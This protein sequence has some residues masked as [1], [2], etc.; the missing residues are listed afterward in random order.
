MKTTTFAPRP[1]VAAADVRR[2]AARVA[3]RVRPVTLIPA[4]A[5]SPGR[6]G[7][8]LASE[9]GQYSGSF[10]ARGAANLV[11]YHLE[12]GS[13]PAAGVVTA[14][15][16]SGNAGLACAWAA[17][18]TDTRATV[19]VP[20]HCPA[21]LVRRLREAGAEVR[22][23]GDAFAAAEAAA[24]AY[25][26]ETGAVLA[27]GHGDPLIAAGAGTLAAELDAAIGGEVDTVVVPVGSG[28]LLAGTCAA[29][30]ATGIKVVG[31]R[32]G[33]PG[34]GPR[35][36]EYAP[37]ACCPVRGAAS[38]VSVAVSH[39]DALHA[40]RAAWRRWR[41]AIEPAA[42]PALAAVLYGAYRPEVFERLAVVLTGANTDPADLPLY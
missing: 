8:Y 16:R 20:A 15:G 29:L 27:S 34:A 11:A 31:V 41:L 33:A 23:G 14:C 9:C 17:T 10:K 36:D 6:A 42:A 4:E 13:M 38:C 18:E 12:H 39:D 25:A 35:G 3:A 19:F 5:G 40:R 37:A 28:T 2:A 7:L 21:H 32:L 1:A 30:E 24:G 26:A 22:A